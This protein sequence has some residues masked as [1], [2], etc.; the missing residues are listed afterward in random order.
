MFANVATAKV[1][2]SFTKSKWIY[3]SLSESSLSIQYSS[4]VWPDGKVVYHFLAMYDNENLP[5]TIKN[6]PL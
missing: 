6:L 5:N 4:P 3:L 1:V 2:F